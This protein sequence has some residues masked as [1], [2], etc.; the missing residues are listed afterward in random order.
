[1]TAPL[2]IRAAVLG[3]VEWMEFAPV[4][5]LPAPGEIVHAVEPFALPAGGGTVAARQMARLGADTLFLTAVGDDSL[6]DRTD[7]ALSELGLDLHVARR[8]QRPQRHGLTHLDAHGERTITILGP[9]LAPRGDDPLPW[10]LLDGR[11][12]CFVTAGDPEAI[13]RA[14]AARVLVA[15]PRALPALAEADVHVD[16]LVGSA[17]DPGEHISADVLPHP[18]GVMVRTQ[19]A[20]GG[21]WERADGVTGEWAAAR[22]PGPPIDAFGC[23]DSF[24]GALTVGLGAGLELDAALALAARAGASCLTGRGPYGAQLTLT[25]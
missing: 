3:H 13:R 18:P 14:R 8:A 23:G 16:V 21:T 9:R 2:P 11:D 24:A 15:T 19:G 1:V 12:A 17:I 7:A 6:G 5:H 25:A 20:D 10:H 22:L 4:D